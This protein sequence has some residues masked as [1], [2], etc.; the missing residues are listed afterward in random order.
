MEFIQRVH[1]LHGGL[2]WSWPGL[3]LFC[4]SAGSKTLN[5]AALFSLGTLASNTSSAH[6]CHRQGGPSSFL[7]SSSMKAQLGLAC[8]ALIFFSFFF[9]G[10]KS[11]IAGER[12]QS[13][14]LNCKIIVAI[15]LSQSSNDSSSYGFCTLSSGQGKGNTLQINQSISFAFA[16]IME[17]Y[18]SKL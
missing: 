2:V 12:S 14:L 6:L 5:F 1:G 7:C 10:G 13:T 9:H 16:H 18:R 8:I 4:Q 17:R 3:V 11:L 15:F